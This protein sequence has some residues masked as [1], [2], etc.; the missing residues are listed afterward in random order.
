MLLKL[1]QELKGSFSYEDE[2]IADKRYIYAFL[3]CGDFSGQGKID[4]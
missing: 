3:C 1:Q 2:N 4:Q